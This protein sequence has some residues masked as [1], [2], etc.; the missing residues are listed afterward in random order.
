VWFLWGLLLLKEYS[1]EEVNAGR[2]GGVDEET[3][4]VWSWWFLESFADCVAE[5]VNA[6]LC[7]FLCNLN[8]KTVHHCLPCA[9]SFL[10]I[11]WENRYKNDIG[12]DCL[13][14]VDGVDCPVHQRYVYVYD[15]RKKKEV[16]ELDKRY[17]S[18][19]FDGPGLRYEIGASIRSPDIVWI[20]GPFLPGNYTDLMIFR[21]GMKQSLDDGEMVEADDIYRD[22]RCK[23]PGTSPHLE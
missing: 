17:Y 6:I 21:E 1:S 11:K 3:F 12:N 22:P 7:L 19:K 13:A 16:K 15:Y 10:R 8:F 5:V 18:K 23:T 4:W 20:N 14:S 2:V 9:F